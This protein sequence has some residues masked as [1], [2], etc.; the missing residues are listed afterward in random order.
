MSLLLTGR[1]KHAVFC[2]SHHEMLLG[3]ATAGRCG[4]LSLQGEP[5]TLRVIL[6]SRYE[7]L[8]DIF[9]QFCRV[10]SI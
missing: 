5:Q 1:K 2:G 6:E 9:A 7:K 3:K 10:F 4:N 8:L